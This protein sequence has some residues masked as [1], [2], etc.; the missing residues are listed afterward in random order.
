VGFIL[1][2]ILSLGMAVAVNNVRRGS[3]F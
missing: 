3:T 2:N 1:G